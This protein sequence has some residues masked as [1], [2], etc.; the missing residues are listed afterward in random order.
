MYILINIYSTKTHAILKI[1]PELKALCHKLLCP[2]EALS[3]GISV[4]LQACCRKPNTLAFQKIVSWLP[5]ALKFFTS[6]T[7]GNFP[8]VHFPLEFPRELSWKAIWLPMKE[9][10]VRSLGQEDTLKGEMVTHSNI[11][12]RKVPWTEEPDRVQSVGSQTD[13]SE[14]THT[15]FPLVQNLTSLCPTACSFPVFVYQVC[16]NKVPQTRRLRNVLSGSPGG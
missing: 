1:C 7:T 5:L 3:F 16:C 8:L 6:L 9:K 2:L 12:D 14:H 13:T 4:S 10:L 11:I 15:P